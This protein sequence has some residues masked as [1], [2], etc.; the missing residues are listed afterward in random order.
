MLG[1]GESGEIMEGEGAGGVVEEGHLGKISH[2]DAVKA[3]SDILASANISLKSDVKEMMESTMALRE[4]MAVDKRRVEAL[5]AEVVDLAKELAKEEG[6]GI[7]CP[8]TR[9]PFDDPV[10]ASD[11]FTY[12]REAIEQWLRSNNRSPQTNQMLQNRLL[13]PNRTLKSQLENMVST[14]ARIEDF[15][16][17]LDET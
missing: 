12:E 5:K 2:A 10:I 11:G 16:V 15:A 13:I 3:A 7:I 17:R 8:I 6:D 14:V 9:C 4:T 1:R